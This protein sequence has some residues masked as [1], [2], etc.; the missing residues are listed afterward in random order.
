MYDQQPDQFSANEVNFQ[1]MLL[2][3]ME[4]VIKV[5]FRGTKTVR[6]Y[7]EDSEK[8]MKEKGK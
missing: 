2:N 8:I 3:N 1:K 5:F 4:S 6:Y 7:P